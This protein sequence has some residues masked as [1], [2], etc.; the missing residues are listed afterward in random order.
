M[1]TALLEEV[2]EIEGRPVLPE[3]VGVGSPGPLDLTTGTI[4]TTPNLEWEGFEVRDRIAEA[5]GLPAALYND[6]NCAAFGEWWCGAGRGSSS[7]VCVTLGTGIGGGFVYEGNPFTG[8]SDSAMEVG[9]IV[10]DPG[11]R[12][13]GCGN[14]GCLE[15]YASGPSIAA[16]AGEAI[17]AGRPSVIPEI[18]TRTGT[19]LSASA[20]HEALAEGDALAAEIVRETGEILGVGLASVAQLL[21]PEAIVI[22]GGVARLG[23]ALFT[24]LRKT[25]SQ[26]V[27]PSV[28]RACRIV[29]GKLAERAGVVGAAGLYLAERAS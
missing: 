4:L 6:A 18:L 12:L 1:T 10:V 7:L 2:V 5:V 8:V 21:N 24:P 17:T 16:R 3:G 11:G 19:L 26:R 15:A 20:V 14:R 23:E 13:C 28:S 22:V 29:P 27:F 9:H 25:F